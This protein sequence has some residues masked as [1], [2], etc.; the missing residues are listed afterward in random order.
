M[1]SNDPEGKMS[2]AVAA[3]KYAGPTKTITGAVLDIDY[4]V[5]GPAALIRLTVMGSDGKSH[6]VFDPSFK[7]YFYLVPKGEVHEQDVMQIVVREPTGVIRPQKVEKV[8]LSLFGKETD[9]FKVT[10]SAPFEIPKLSAAAS[11]LGERYE[12]DIPFSKRYVIDKGIEQLTCFSISVREENGKLAAESL[13]REPGAR[14]EPN[15]LCFDIETYNPLGVPRP[16][17]DPIIMISY[18]YNA[19]GK[20]GGGVLTFK[21]IDLPFVETLGSEV[22]MLERFSS[23]LDELDIDIVS[24]YN[25]ANFDIK[26]M[27]DR[28]KA[29]RHDLDLSRFDGGTRYERHGLVDR[30]KIAGRAHVD[31]YQVVKF[32]SV[33]GA[34]ERILKLNSYTLK[35]VYEALTDDKKLTVEKRDIYKLW[36]GSDDDLK[37]LARYNMNDSEALHKVFDMLAPITMELSRIT[38]DTLSD[39]AV[40]TTGQLVEF[41][42]MR[43]AH[44]FGE[45]VPNKPTEQEI[46]A[47]LANP[48]IGAYVKTPLPGIYENLAIFDFRGLYPSIIVSHNIDPSSI[49]ETCTDYYESPDGIRFDKHRRSITPTILRSMIEQRIEVKRQFKEHPDS[50]TL[51]SRSQALKIVANSFYGYLGYARS[52]WYSRACASSVTA[53]GRQYITQTIDEAERRGFRVIYGDTDSLVMLLGG[54]SKDEAMAFMREYNSG[55]PESMELELEDFYA[56]GVFVGKKS[57]KEPVGAKKKYALISERGRIKVRGFELVRRDWSRI[58]RDTQMRVLEAILKDGSAEKAAELVRHVI[59]ELRSGKVPMKELVINTQLRKS[60]DSYDSKS[61]ELAAARKALESGAKRRDELEHAVIGY[62]ITKSGSSVSDKARLEEMA[63]DYDPD[64]YI[65]HQV[66]PATMRILKELNFSEEELRKGGKQSKL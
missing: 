57:D 19:R 66:L 52:R 36:D 26:Y 62:V 7:P 64:Y 34:A 46:R 6:E 2:G 49:C 4:L 47:R 61:P 43:Y 21:H 27:L 41:M 31:M 15:V 5:A 35:N 37:I 53:Y 18:S 40:S 24:G 58:A 10:A 22:E 39:V 56:R 23:L 51:G 9:A 50:L 48:I 20:R 32:I 17:K 3:S 14:V 1:Q 60:I 33:V 54:K 30:V 65:S 38:G 42:L 63:K 59:E 13:A 44:N 11:S 12:D 8:K 16:E 29:L 25:S 45:L 28:A 55:L